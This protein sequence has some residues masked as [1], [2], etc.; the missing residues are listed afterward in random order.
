MNLRV[1]Q[2][3]KQEMEGDTSFQ[4]K[5][6]GLGQI[7]GGKYYSQLEMRETWH[8]GIK[9][10]IEIG[11]NRV[12]LEGQRIDLIENVMN[13]RQADFVQKLFKLCQEYKCAI[14]YHSVEGMTIVDKG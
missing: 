10:G 14:Q 6:S 7:F 2:I 5:A 4:E 11:L 9:H 13:R 3:F 8:K 12:S 1:E